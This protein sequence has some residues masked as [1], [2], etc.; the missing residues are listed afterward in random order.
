MGRL[1]FLHRPDADPSLRRLT[2]VE[3]VSE[4]LASAILY[5]DTG[6]ARFAGTS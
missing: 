3:V 6:V 5:G 2:A 1:S 4:R